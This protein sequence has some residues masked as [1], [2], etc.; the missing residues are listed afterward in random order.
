MQIADVFCQ[1]KH[2]AKLGKHC[3][4][5]IHTVLSEQH[6]WDSQKDA[7]QL[8]LILTVILDNIGGKRNL[9]LNDTI[10]FPLPPQESIAFFVCLFGLFVLFCL[11]L[12]ETQGTTQ[13]A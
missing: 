5:G 13:K 2:Q 7:V 12:R 10:S 8:F 9:P 11:L 6:I 4:S 3:L 1:C